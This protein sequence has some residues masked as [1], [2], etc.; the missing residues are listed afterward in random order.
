MI[1]LFLILTMLAVLIVVVLARALAFK[2][3]E[4]PNIPAASETF[5][6]AKAI[7]DLQAL[8][9]CR[10]VSYTDKG[11]EDEAEFDKLVAKLPELFPHV[12][13]ACKLLQPSDRSL[14][15]F[16]KGKT[17][18]KPGVLMAHYDVVPVNEQTWSR[19]AFDA[20]IIDGVMWGR[21]TLDT[22]GTFCGVLEAADHLIA[23]GFVPEHDLYL[24][25]AGDEEISG[26]GAPAIV[27]WFEQQKIHPDFVLD[28]G[29]AVVTGVFP[30]VEQPIAVIGIAEKGPMNVKLTLDSNGG[31]A[32]TPPG[33]TPV[34]VLAR[35]V[36]NIESHPFPFHLTPPAEKM[37]DTL[38]RRSTFVYRMIFAN[39]WLFRPVLDLICRISGGELN[40]LVRTTVAFTQMEGSAAAN[41][42]PP[43]AWVGANLRVMCGET[44]AEAQQRLQQLCGDARIK[45]EVMP[46][47]MD[48][49]PVSSTEGEPWQRLSTAIR[50]VW[51]GT[52]VS[53]YLMLACSD[54]RHYGK[55]CDHVYRFSAMAL[56]KEERGLIHGNDERVPVAT[57]LKT[58]AFYLQVIRRS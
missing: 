26:H 44:V 55:I 27:Q 14:L 36:S 30:G 29:G 19:P 16:W 41:V 21:G 23:E 12:H 22:K 25:F 24:A 4:E 28:E 40:A 46:G 20:A 56:S 57:F 54:S 35:A 53:P 47:S 39:L 7:N 45:V 43:H 11:L 13:Q 51:N 31:H 2:P 3:A 50:A 49:S 15:Y 18:D 1:I 37:F 58:V 8:I 32:S 33:H 52:V 38:G 34:G 6:E 48:P 9:R 42:L 5:D 10:T 17:A